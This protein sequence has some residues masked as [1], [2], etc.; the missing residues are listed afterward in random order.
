MT[1]DRRPLSSC[2][3]PAVLLLAG[4]A[5]TA[6]AQGGV[7]GIVRDAAGE[8]IAGARVIAE[9]LETSQIRTVVT[10]GSG[11]FVFI[12]L[13][14]GDWL[15]VIQAD[16]YREEQGYSVVRRSGEP[17]RVD[18]TWTSIRSTPVAPTTGVLAGL[19]SA[20]LLARLRGA[21]RLFD[22]GDY[23]GAIEAW[24]GILEPRTRPDQR[25][26]VNRPRLIGP[27]GNRSGR[28]PPI[29][30]RWPPTRRIGKRAPRSARWT[31]NSRAAG[32]PSRPP[33]A[34][35]LYWRTGVRGRA[36]AAP[37]GPRRPSG[38]GEPE[39]KGRNDLRVMSSCPG[40]AGR[41]GVRSFQMRKKISSS[42]VVAARHGPARPQTSSPRAASCSAASPMPRPGT[43]SPGPPCAST[44][45]AP[46]GNA[47]PDDP[48]TEQTSD[49]GE[50]HD[51][52]SA[53]RDMEHHRRGRRTIR[54]RPAP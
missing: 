46:L 54:P 50:V 21:E 51:A 42:L 31:G 3:L 44:A 41:P 40:A 24:R 36:R 4:S 5:A 49:S 30:A 18:I 13:A 43:P 34:V 12:G 2:L 6:A 26:S 37:A 22:G 11:R 14:G 17:A 19:K 38:R 45:H 52:R 28:W 29:A 23:D 33:R 1:V 32:D 15:F 35:R 25:E 16:G 27:S 20:D 9:S 48:R 53:E 7:R 10:N 39:S 47:E 8:G